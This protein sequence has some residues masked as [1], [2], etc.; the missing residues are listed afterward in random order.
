MKAGNRL[1]PGPNAFSAASDTVWVDSAGLHL[2]IS[3]R[4]G[5]WTSAEV[6]LAASRGY[7][8]YEFETTSRLDQLDPN[9][10]LGFFTYNYPDPA[11]AHRELDIEF[12][13]R[14]AGGGAGHFVVQNGAGPSFAF[15][16]PAATLV[17]HVIDWRPNRVAFSSGAASW[18]YSGTGV[19][20]PGGEHMRLN[21]WLFGGRP[22]ASGAAQEVVFSRFRFDG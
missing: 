15:A 4:S 1:A 19:P 5:T 6:V 9:A 3:N 17:T 11:F 21:L 12:S 2:R 10:V 18:T 20:P 8:R 16:A 7:G 22:P 13:P 14:L